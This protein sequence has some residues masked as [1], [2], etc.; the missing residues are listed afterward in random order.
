[1]IRFKDSRMEMDM[2]AEMIKRLEVGQKIEMTLRLTVAEIEI[3]GDLSRPEFIACFE[4]R[5]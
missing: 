1:M 4:V 3:K 2:T 5:Q